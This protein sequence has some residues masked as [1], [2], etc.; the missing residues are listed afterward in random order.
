M[1][2]LVRIRAV[3]QHLCYVSGVPELRNLSEVRPGRW[4][5]R[6][7]AHAFERMAKAALVDGV[8][9]TIVSAWRS[10][11]E[12]RRLYTQWERGERKLRPAR[13]GWSLHQS[14]MAVDILRSHDDPDGGG[15]LVGPTD[16]WLETHAAE[17]GWYRTVPAELW[18]Y[19]Y[20][21][22]PR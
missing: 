2:D 4:L 1:V 3:R 16:K 11:D 21:G 14:G 18:H 19:E 12:Q 8:E 10:M 9:L 15:P 20:K 22:E 13:P 6:D 7:A 17:H 5:D